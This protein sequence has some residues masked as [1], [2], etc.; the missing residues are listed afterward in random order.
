MSYTFTSQYVGPVHGNDGIIKSYARHIGDIPGCIYP[1]NTPSPKRVWDSD[2]DDTQH[3][4]VTQ[5]TFFF[6]PKGKLT[7]TARAIRPL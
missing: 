7:H 4:K 6:D 3:W 2:Y 1:D 5:I